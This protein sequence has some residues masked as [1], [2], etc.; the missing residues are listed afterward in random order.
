MC[1]ATGIASSPRVVARTTFAL[2]GGRASVTVADESALDAA[3]SAVRRTVQAFDDACSS[4]RADSELTLVNASAGEPIVVG[5]LLLTAVRAALRAARETG[6]AV[7]P[8][9]G[10]VLIAHGLLPR[11]SPTARARIERAPGHLTVTLD[12]VASSVQAP[13]GV[14]L[15]LGATAKALAA[16]MAAA[17]AAAA[18]RCGVLV[19][20]CGD[21]AVAGEPPAGGWRVRVTDDHRRDDGAG[22]TVTITEGGLATSS[23]TVRRADDGVTHHLIDPGTGLA[24]AGPWRTATVAARTCLEANTAS[25]AAIVLGAGAPGWLRARGLPARL[26][27]VDAN[28]RHLGGWPTEGDD[29]CPRP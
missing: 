23:V 9:V 2:W 10:Q 8:T 26:A 14:C 16:D 18:G 20:L 25:T 1:P 12:E 28:V 19:A 22:Q 29:L 5:G 4:F 17:G 21:I 3:V 6:G 15:D 24:T 27:G 11:L 7:D 13:R